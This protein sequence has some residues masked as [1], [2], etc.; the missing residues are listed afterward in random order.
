MKASATFEKKSN[1][2]P[3]FKKDAKDSKKKDAKKDDCGCDD[4]KKKKP[5]TDCKD[6]DKKKDKKKAK[7][8]NEGSGILSFKQFLNESE[9]FQDQF[10]PESEFENEEDTDGEIIPL[11]GSEEETHTDE[12]IRAAHDGTETS[13]FDEDG[14]EGFEDEGASDNWDGNSSD[15][16]MDM[17]DEPVIPKRGAS[18][19]EKI[20]NELMSVNNE[21]GS[22][23]DQYKSD[24]DIQSYKKNASPLLA[25]RKELQAKL[26]AAFNVGGQGEDEFATEEEDIYTF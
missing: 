4:K 26:D 14:E 2:F 20:N 12:E 16:G 19:I 1:K 7:K 6:K 21:I 13:E 3:F 8:V 17:D 25:K 23:L 11:E 24:N 10:S 22:L 5:C 9:E 15:A 18:K